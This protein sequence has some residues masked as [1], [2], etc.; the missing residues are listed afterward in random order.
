VEMLRKINE[1][2]YVIGDTHLFHNNI[3][4]YEPL[5]R[6]YLEEGAPS[7]EDWLI[8]RWNSVVR[9][10]DLVL[11]L[12]DFAFKPHLYAEYA[13]FMNGKKILII[14]NHDAKDISVYKDLFEFVI[15]DGTVW[16]VRDNQITYL[17]THHR[18]AN[19]IVKTIGEYKILFSHYP[20]YPPEGEE[21]PVTE[22]LKKV[23]EKLNCNLNIHGHIHSKELNNPLLINASVEKIDFKPVKI[24]ELID[25]VRKR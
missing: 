19:G 1:N 22:E 3:I 6:K 25:R 13:L 17:K 20:I 14:G 11:H 4:K 2:T 10:T 18:L 15:S 8:D 7:H 23:F 12:G 16:I 24:K 9:E 5:R 21:S